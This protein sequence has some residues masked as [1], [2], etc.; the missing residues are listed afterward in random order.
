VT[1][2]RDR[3]G[4]ALVLTVDRP[5][6]KNALSRD[7]ARE[8]F[9][10]CAEAA[11][12]ATVRA[13]VVTGAGGTFVSGGD[14]RELRSATSRADAEALSDWG[15]ALCA[16]LEDLPVPVIAA[17]DG[18]AIGGGAE[19]AC[20]CDLR[21]AGASASF[22]FRQARMGVTTAWGTSSRLPAIVGAGH[23][24]RLLLFGAAIGAEEAA[25]IGLVDEIASE[26]SALAAALA[27]VAELGRASPSAVA[28]MKALLVHARRPSDAARGLERASFV[29]SWV[30]ADHVDAVEAFFEKR[31]PRWSPRQP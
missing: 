14:L 9:E 24:A 27:C 11:T 31:P 22:S 4:A 29:E 1:L 26:T 13:V 2:R 3:E 19:L 15:A 10:A 28:R 23:A 7:I 6:A 5:D 16:R 21:V 20:A 18:A 17:I 12:D 25:R 30:S 8:L